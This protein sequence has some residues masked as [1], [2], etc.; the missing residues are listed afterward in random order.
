MEKSSENSNNL[1]IAFQIY[2]SLPTR[3]QA[4]STMKGNSTSALWNFLQS[5]YTL[6]NSQQRNN[7]T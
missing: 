5:S 3:V 6:F 1:K 4:C 7:V 2:T